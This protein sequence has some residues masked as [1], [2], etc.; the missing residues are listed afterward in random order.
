MRPTGSV[1]DLTEHHLLEGVDE[2]L[3]DPH[4]LALL[5]LVS[6]LVAAVEPTQQG[7]PSEPVP[8]LPTLTELVDSFIDVGYR[9]T[10]AVLLVIAQLV[11]DDLMRERIR[12]SVAERRHPMPGW[13]LRLDHVEPYRAVKVTHVLGDGDDIIIGV[14]LPGRRECSIVVYIDHNMGT[15]VKD[16]FIL[17]GSLEDV[18]EVWV[19][20]DPER[21]S[22]IADLA[23]ADARTQVVDAIEKGAITFPPFE[24]ETWPMCR[25]LVRWVLSMMPAGGTGYVRP[26]WNEKQLA[27]L[28]DRFFASKAAT[29]VADDDDNRSLLESILWFGTDYGPG[30]PMRW[31]PSSVEILLDD[32]IP[33]KLVAPV[34]Y[35]DKVPDLLRAFVRYCHA[36]RG[37]P[38]ELTDQTIELLDDAEP[39]Y[40]QT[41]RTPRHQ[42]PM[43]LL[44]QMGLLDGEPPAGMFDGFSLEDRALEL[45]AEEVGG[46]QVLDALDTEP[47]PDEAFAWS[48]IPEDIHARV[49]EVLTLV[50]GCA[51][52]LFDTEFRT[53]ARRVLA[54][55]ASGDPEIFRRRGKAQTAACAVCWIVAKANRSLDLYQGPGVQ[56]KQLMAHFGLT[57]SSSQRAEPMLRALGVD[58]RYGHTSLG[59]ADFLVSLKRD[60]TIGERDYYRAQQ[61]ST[62]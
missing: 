9:Q 16:A 12:R 28:T 57:G 55:V 60:T 52:A 42:G 37:I 34:E 5:T 54:R 46:T 56:A 59:S 25:P 19:E 13:L 58:W 6:G 43:A 23:L 33:R 14:R 8:G 1:D 30:D 7:M 44:E 4:P 49:D 47:L 38:P 2:A 35:L 18:I 10:D 3:R 17:D 27:D 51:D 22:E 11:G 20:H 26:E 50:D 41:I 40:R 62:E 39:D 31:S 29:A 36:E 53:A 45:L 61:S 24:S 21:E 48:G 15:L 32:W